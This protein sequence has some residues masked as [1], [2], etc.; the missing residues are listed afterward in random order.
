MVRKLLATAVVTTALV[1]VA[2][3]PAYASSTPL[4]NVAVSQVSCDDGGAAVNVAVSGGF[5]RATYQASNSGGIS[6]PINFSTNRSGAGS[7]LLHNVV[8]P[9]GST[10]GTATVAVTANGQTTNVSL[11]V[12]CQ[13]GKGD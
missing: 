12:N 4:G 9:N 13:S 10:V 7:G 2:A 1:G 11:N 8:T 5:A 3:V 6:S